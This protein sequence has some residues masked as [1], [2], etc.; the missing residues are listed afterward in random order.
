MPRRPSFC[1]DQ[2]GKAACGGLSGRGR[3]QPE[4][5]AT[6]IVGLGLDREKALIGEEFALPRLPGSFCDGA[7][8]CLQS[9][10]AQYFC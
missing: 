2:L 10:V 1:S 3:E 5:E 6:G 9:F 7:I 8:F 4:G